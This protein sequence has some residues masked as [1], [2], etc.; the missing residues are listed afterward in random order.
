MILKLNS[1]LPVLTDLE[2]MVVNRSAEWNIRPKPPK[3]VYRNSIADQN[4]RK[5]NLLRL[6]RKSLDKPN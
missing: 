6:K 3:P 4:R 2:E 5:L 1:C